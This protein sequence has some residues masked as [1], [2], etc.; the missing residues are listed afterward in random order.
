MRILLKKTKKTQHITQNILEKSIFAQIN[1][2]TR[3]KSWRKK[4]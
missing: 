2:K 3:S 1:N 4:S